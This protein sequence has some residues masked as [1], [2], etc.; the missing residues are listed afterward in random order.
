MPPQPVFVLAVVLMSLSAASST[1]SQQI[2]SDVVISGASLNDG[3]G[4][5]TCDEDGQIYR[6]PTSA[7]PGGDVSLMRVAK[8]GS[9]LLFTLP[10]PEWSIQVFGATA[11]G[12]IVLANPSEPTE[13]GSKHIYR[14]DSNGSLRTH[15]IVSLDFQ[16]V[17]IT[18]TKSHMTIIV[19][20]RPRTERDKEARTYGGAVL[21]ASDQVVKL[22]EF[23]PAPQGNRWTV[24]D[25]SGIAV[26]DDDSVSVVLE[27]GQAPTYAIA[28]ISES[29]RIRLEPLATVK[30]ARYHAWFLAKGVAAEEYQFA[31]EKPLAPIKFDAFDIAS[32]RKISTKTLPLVGFSVA[33]YM[34]NEISMFAHS[35]R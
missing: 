23:P 26:A 15:H 30:G 28:E 6:A 14:F 35:T 3:Y 9:T 20:Y 22:F 29:G 19:G 11:S 25:T 24:V 34:E 12:L 16:P 21:N 10:K 7:R 13:A 27:S 4:R 1:Y 33:C 17:A 8:D 2:T 31:S 18:E 5:S 32:G